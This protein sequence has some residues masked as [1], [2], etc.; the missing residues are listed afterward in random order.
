MNPNQAQTNQVVSPENLLEKAFENQTLTQDTVIIEDNSDDFVTH[1]DQHK[2]DI[3]NSWADFYALKTENLVQ[4]SPEKPLLNFEV[5]Q[6]IIETTYTEPVKYTPKKE[7]IVFDKKPIY[8]ID[9]QK[10]SGNWLEDAGFQL[11]FKGLFNV[12]GSF[13]KSLFGAM[14]IFKEI[15]LD[16]GKIL[17]TGFKKDKPVKKED[18]SKAKKEAEKKRK[19]ANI[20]AFYDGVRAQMSASVVSVEAVRVESQER[21]NV[22]KTIKLTNAS[23]KGIKDNFGRLTVY[24]ANMFEREQM[25]QE[26]TYK[27]IEKQ[28]KMASAKGP[29]LN[30]DKAAEGG[31]LSSTGG[32]GAG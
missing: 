8:L 6:T 28:Q 31:F 29:D 10:G 16:T 22:N 7:E 1:S 26:K 25:E 11:N 2:A 9:E 23:Y 18:P 19:F 27:K 21:E 24:A 4:P 5:K 20:R 32:Q 14:N 12:I 17:Y 30:L 15:G 3:S 13:G